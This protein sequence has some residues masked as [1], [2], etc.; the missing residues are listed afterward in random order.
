MFVKSQ[1]NQPIVLEDDD[2]EPPLLSDVSAT[3]NDEMVTTRVEVRL[4]GCYEMKHF[5]L[6]QNS[7][8][9]EIISWIILAIG[10]NWLIS[11]LKA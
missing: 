4:Q 10:I 2:D 8:F 6:K 1:P 5:S 11:I 9:Y 7:I 3:K